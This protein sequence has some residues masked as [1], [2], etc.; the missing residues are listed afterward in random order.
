MKSL[1]KT[2]LLILGLAVWMPGRASEPLAITLIPGQSNPASP[3]M[4]DRL[5]F[6]TVITNPGGQPVHG[7]V[8]WI[9]LVQVDPGHEQ[10]MDLEDWSAHKAVTQALLGP[11]E[12]VDMTWPMRLIQAGTYRVVVSAMDRET[13]RVMTSPVLDFQVRSKPVVESRRILPVAL[14]VPMV[15]LGMLVSVVLRRRR[16]RA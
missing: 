16:S 7:L 15:L 10:P 9:S 11:G 13:G 2:F 1:Y 5:T 12:H 3:Q 6:Q 14:G 8:A 4:G